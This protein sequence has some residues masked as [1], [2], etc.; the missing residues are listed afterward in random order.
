MLSSQYWLFFILLGVFLILIPFSTAGLP[1]QSVFNVEVTHAQ[2]RFRF[3]HEN[4]LIFVQMA[5]VAGGAAM[6]LSLFSFLR[7]KRDTTIF[8]SL[9][10]NRWELFIVRSGVGVV[11]LAA[12]VCIPMFLSL[13]LNKIALGLYPGAV[14]RCFY[15]C[16]GICLTAFSSFFL[17]VLVCALS[18][19][20]MESLFYGS[21][22]AGGM[23]LLLYGCNLLVNKLLWGGARGVTTY[24][25]N[26]IPRA[27]LVSAWKN[28]NPLLFFYDGLKEQSV[29]MRSGTQE[30]PSDLKFSVLV[31]W[32]VFTVCLFAGSYMALKYR[33]AEI[34]GIT[35][36]NSILSEVV[37]GLTAFFA[38]AAVISFLYEY[39]NILAFPAGAVV[40][41]LIHLF[42]RKTVFAYEITG[43]KAAVSAFVQ[44]GLMACFVTVL[45][46]DGFGYTN[47]V[48]QREDFV[49][50]RFS[51]VGSPNYLSVPTMGSST[52]NGYYVQ[53]S[54]EL[55]E[56]EE[57]EK[58][59]RIQKKFVD[60]GK[61]KKELNVKAFSKT[62]IPYDIEFSYTDTVGKNYYWYY[63]RASLS[64]LAALL[65]ADNFE[66]V[67][68]SSGA[69]VEGDV[70][71]AASVWSAQA[72]REGDVYL[73]DSRY[74]KREQLSLEAKDRESLLQAIAQDVEKQTEK[75]RYY[76]D[77]E[78]K[79][80]LM[81]TRT[82]EHDYES[83]SY[84]LN[85]TFVYVTDEFTN[86]LKWLQGKNYHLQPQGQVESITLQK[87]NPYESINGLN[88]PM[89]MYFMSYRGTAMNNFLIP[90]DFGKPYVIT[91]AE[92]L[93]QLS[94]CLRNTWFMD[95]GGYMAAVKTA[96]ADG[97]SYMFIPEDKVPDFVKE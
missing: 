73:S 71:E 70:D 95:E 43:K 64:Q 22:L 12:A 49:S 76:P 24:S 3:I 97:Y 17:M 6:A 78:A 26:P 46:T 53:C 88:Y 74:Q 39:L 23:T 81:F 41:L 93:S 65:A 47:R 84:H 38:G 15:V 10:M 77:Q 66:S 7:S 54:M 62:V 57:I 2:M 60:S 30:F 45:M 5:A 86:T 82:G 44:L 83:F 33:K 89:S 13:L 16:G 68:W 35:G 19:T 42:W 36:T 52:G 51:Y 8:M 85:N 55:T 92:E 87:F 72:Y 37:I 94:S 59:I 34:T 69:A 4:F 90:K 61:I 28:W 79:A 31:L 29:F 75:D 1:G 67:R 96:G 80:I 27:S 9:G 48:L 40:F 56:P 50:A 18:G 63:D 32:C 14:E 58:L 91:G 20:L 11:M 25:G 21:A